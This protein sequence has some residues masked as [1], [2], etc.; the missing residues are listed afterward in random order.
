MPHGNFSDAGLIALV[1]DAGE[2]RDAAA[3]QPARVQ[4]HGDQRI[5]LVRRRAPNAAN[6]DDQIP[7]GT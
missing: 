6:P 5:D 1:I 4:R 7:R 3:H 2:R